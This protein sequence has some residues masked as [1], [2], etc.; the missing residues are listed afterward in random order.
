[1]N[2][3]TSG[4][5]RTVLIASS[6]AD[7]KIWDPVVRH[8][9]PHLQAI[10][11]EGDAV[12]SQRRPLKVELTNVGLNVWYD[13]RELALSGIAAALYLRPNLAEPG[14]ARWDDYISE[15]QARDALYRTLWQQV[16]EKAW[17]NHPDK[18]RSLVG[19]VGQLAVAREAG[20]LVPPHTLVTGDMGDVTETFPA[21]A[22]HKRTPRIIFGSDGAQ[23]LQP[24]Y[25]PDVAA[26]PLDK[27]DPLTSYWQDR[28][29]G[30]PWH[31]LAIGDQIFSVYQQ[32]RD[33]GPGIRFIPAPLP[34]QVQEQC[35]NYLSIAGLGMG[36]FSLIE[37]ESGIACVGFNPYGR[38]GWMEQDLR[39]PVSETI[40][41]QLATI[42]MQP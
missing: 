12:A 10:V 32:P 4:R 16:P 39:L 8:L 18:M 37:N 5:E 42:A 29:E 31:A 28:I 26:L 30:R 36:A 6:H 13:G 17:L 19:L 7:K 3:A 33:D 22:I 23:V 24:M 1:M 25:I 15:E 20:F 11:F 14:N 38:P 9:P 27:L 2:D 40:A 41:K 34:P 21:G 35:R